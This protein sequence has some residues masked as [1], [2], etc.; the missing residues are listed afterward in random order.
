M[1]RS[2]ERQGH[3][4]P[5]AATR[6]L[7]QGLGW[8]SIGLG[9]AEVV[10]PGTLAR[11]LGMRGHETLIRAYGVREIGAG[12]GILASRDPTPWIWGRI[13]GDALD[14]A[15]LG[16]G[17]EGDNPKKGN[18]ALALTAVAGVTALDVACAQRLGFGQLG[19]GQSDERPARPR[20]SY[21]DRSGFPKGAQAMR[22]AAR[23]FQA[24]R[25]MRAPDALRPWTEG[26]PAGASPRPGATV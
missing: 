6:A 8:F 1:H 2:S 7:A 20:P 16:V 5:D 22:G 17:L 15:T 14:I 10:M 21:A 23:D 19:L 9:L 3:G 24:P 13:A 11:M 25:D 4:A 18:V 12:I 26:R